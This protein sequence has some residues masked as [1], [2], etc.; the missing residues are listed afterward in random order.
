MTNPRSDVD[1]IEFIVREV[2]RRLTAGGHQVVSGRSSDA[3][4]GTNAPL[5]RDLRLSERLVT[6]ATLDGRLAGVSRVIVPI[7]A[8]VTPAVRDELKRKNIRL[9]KD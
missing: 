3:A 2:I 1:L 9:E 5:Q 6:L 4:H 7:R 8:V